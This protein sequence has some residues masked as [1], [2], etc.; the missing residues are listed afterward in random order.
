MT[1]YIPFN[2]YGISG[3]EKFAF[4]KYIKDIVVKQM[5]SIFFRYYNKIA[6]CCKDM[7]IDID[8]FRKLLYNV[9]DV[10]TS[11]RGCIIS[12]NKNIKIGN[13]SFYGAIAAVNYGSQH[14]GL[15]TNIFDEGFKEIKQLM[16]QFCNQFKGV[17]L[18]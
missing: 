5:Y 8:K 13:R 12:V 6:Q 7:S 17:I 9:I 16:P 4:K 1:I 2:I 18:P 14:T 11:N 3:Y 15:P 10:N